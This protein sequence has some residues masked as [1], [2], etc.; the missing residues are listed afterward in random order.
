MID[1][2][3]MDPGNSWQAART[4]LLKGVFNSNLESKNYRL[5]EYNCHEQLIW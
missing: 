5:I 3:T 1:L 2:K 4:G